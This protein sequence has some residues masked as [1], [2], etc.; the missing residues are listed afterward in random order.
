VASN[1]PIRLLNPRFVGRDDKGRPFVLTAQSAVRDQR[2]YQRVLLDHPTLALDNGG[3]QPMRVT[4]RSGVYHE[5]DR[6]LD[7]D[8]GVRLA[9][10][11]GVFN[12]AVSRYDTKSG[13]LTGSG[14]IHGAGPLGEINATSYGVYEK[15][16]RML[17]NGR[18]HA[19]INH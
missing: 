15:G 2:D 7:L 8:G 13:V 18:V 1:A 10:D 14:P 6:K 9:S 12:T 5:G 4:S 11:Q 3:P 17:F 16:D 19:R